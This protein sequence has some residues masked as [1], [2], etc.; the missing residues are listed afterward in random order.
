[1]I[2]GFIIKKSLLYVTKKTIEGIV[3]DQNFLESLKRYKPGNIP[4]Y[5]IVKYG[6]DAVLIL[7]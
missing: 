5:K 7:I 4:I 3:N 1:M 2:I 6:S